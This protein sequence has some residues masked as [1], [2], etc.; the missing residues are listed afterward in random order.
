M[1]VHTQNLAR[2]GIFQYF[3][4]RNI[5]AYGV[6]LNV[7]KRRKVA[8]IAQSC[9]KWAKQCKVSQNNI[10]HGTDSLIGLGKL[11][12]P[13]ASLSHRG[14]FG[15]GALLFNIQLQESYQRNFTK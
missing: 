3:T 15:G 14:C 10:S 2:S 12:L 7:V 11:H 8:K 9:V 13:S 5:T 1:I 6:C 4:R